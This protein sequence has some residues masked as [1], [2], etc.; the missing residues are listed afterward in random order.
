MYIELI[1]EFTSYNSGNLSLHVVAATHLPT[2]TFFILD[3]TLR[4]EHIFLSF[5]FFFSYSHLVL[6]RDK[7]EIKDAIF[8][9]KSANHYEFFYARLSSGVGH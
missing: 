8:D 6:L 2:V 7:Y 1:I 4:I 9:Y 3:L 5:F